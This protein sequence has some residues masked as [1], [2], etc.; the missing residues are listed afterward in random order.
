MLFCLMMPLIATDNVFIMTNISTTC[1]NQTTQVTNIDELPTDAG[2]RK[3]CG[4][5]DW[6]GVVAV[7]GNGPSAQRVCDVMG[8]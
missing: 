8:L 3:V 1:P 4:V 5:S 2:M 7:Y 6:T